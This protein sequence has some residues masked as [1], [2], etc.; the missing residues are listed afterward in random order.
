MPV[1]ELQY[2]RQ[3]AVHLKISTLEKICSVEIAKSETIGDK[4]ARNKEVREQVF[5]FIIYFCTVPIRSRCY[6]KSCHCQYRHKSQNEY[7]FQFI[8]FTFRLNCYLMVPDF[9]F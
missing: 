5:I 7:L 3:L 6:V 2:L 9:S 4:L 8:L 1:D